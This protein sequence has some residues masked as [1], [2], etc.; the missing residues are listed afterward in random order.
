M[1]PIVALPRRA[2]DRP[3]RFGELEDGRWFRSRELSLK[4][5]REDGRREEV[6]LRNS[7]L[8]EELT[9]LNAGMRAR[10]GPLGFVS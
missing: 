8:V 6:Y 1:Q 2:E 10:F 9:P 4:L 7:E 3:A 5:E